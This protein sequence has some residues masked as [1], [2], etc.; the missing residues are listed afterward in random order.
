MERSK[1]EWRGN[2]R[3]KGDGGQKLQNKDREGRKKI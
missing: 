3:K 1:E 2:L